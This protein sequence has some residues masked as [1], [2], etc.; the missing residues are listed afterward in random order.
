MDYL[1]YL[2]EVYRENKLKSSGKMNFNLD[3]TEDLGI[4]WLNV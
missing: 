3:K 1:L 4:E 2:D